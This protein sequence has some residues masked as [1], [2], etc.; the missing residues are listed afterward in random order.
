MIMKDADLVIFDIVTD[1]L[2]FI[3]FRTL[4]SQNCS[5]LGSIR[6]RHICSNEYGHSTQLLEVV[7]P[8]Q[9][10]QSLQTDIQ[11]VYDDGMLMRGSVATEYRGSKHEQSNRL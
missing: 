1:W 11:E 6:A 8:W 4:E 3:N 5:L 10:T 9:Y 2:K 7:L